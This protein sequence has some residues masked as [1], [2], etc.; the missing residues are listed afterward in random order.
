DRWSLPRPTQ[1]VDQADVY[2]GTIEDRFAFR[3]VVGNRLAFQGLDQGGLRLIPDL[4]ASEILAGVEGIAHGKIDRELLE[5]EA[6]QH[7][8]SERQHT[9]DLRAELYRTA[10]D[11][12]VILGE[13]THAHRAVHGAG[14][15]VAIDGAELRPT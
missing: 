11:V 9:R 1:G 4:V 10:E 12:G 13:A 5:A 3:P 2:L 14:A 7:E 6:T 15:L 8:M